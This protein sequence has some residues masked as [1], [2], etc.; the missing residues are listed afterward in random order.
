[1][2]HKFKGQKLKDIGL[3]FGVGVSGVSQTSRRVVLQITDNKELEKKSN[4][5]I[6]HLDLSTVYGDVVGDVGSKTI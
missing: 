4:K 3:L 2:C 5:I 6:S 1:V